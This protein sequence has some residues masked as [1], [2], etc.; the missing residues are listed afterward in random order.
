VKSSMRVQN[1]NKNNGK[2]TSVLAGDRLI[3]LM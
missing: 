1:K 3:D 2:R